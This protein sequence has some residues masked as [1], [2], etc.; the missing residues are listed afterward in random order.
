MLLLITNLDRASSD[1]L[2][3]GVCS[4][5][6]CVSDLAGY[7]DT[8]EARIIPTYHHHY[9]ELNVIGVQSV[10]ELVGPVDRDLQGPPTV[11]SSNGDFPIQSGKRDA[12]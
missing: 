11:T 8:H 12:K 6:V 4:V 9:G 3:N 10:P 5:H 2:L 1:Y 7:V